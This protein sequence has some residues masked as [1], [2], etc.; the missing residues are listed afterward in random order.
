MFIKF[1]FI[2]IYNS[3][4]NFYK[5]VFYMSVEKHNLEMVKFLLNKNDIEVNMKYI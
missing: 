2:F 5:P 1:H 4:I 3:F